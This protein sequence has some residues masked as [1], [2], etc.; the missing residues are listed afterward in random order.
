MTHT[1]YVIA[2]YGVAAITILGLILSIYFGGRR[3]Q[4]D[5]ARLEASG[6]RR[7]SASAVQPPEGAAK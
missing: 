2:S 4:R 3:R 5:L 6:I 1:T 7:R